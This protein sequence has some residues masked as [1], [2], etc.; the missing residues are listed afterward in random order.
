[1][2]L[3]TEVKETI[4]V[5]HTEVKVELK[6]IKDTLKDHQIKYAEFKSNTINCI[7]N[8]DVKIKNLEN[9]FKDII[10]EDKDDLKKKIIWYKTVAFRIAL[11]VC[12]SSGLTAL[13]LKLL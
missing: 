12:G 5:N 7:D 6:D 2:T 3:L 1:M 11:A 9:G 4:G 10:I 8:H 13:I